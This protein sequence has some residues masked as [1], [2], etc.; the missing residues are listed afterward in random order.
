MH[1]PKVILIKDSV[2][3]R[4]DCWFVDTSDDGYDTQ[5]CLHPEKEQIC[6]NG[7]YMFAIK[8]LMRKLDNGRLIW[9]MKIYANSFCT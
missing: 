6:Y 7:K 1:D 5:D 3:R 9:D 8:R 4:S 2:P